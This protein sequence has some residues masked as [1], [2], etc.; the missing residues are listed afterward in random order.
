MTVV[1]GCVCPGAVTTTV[2]ACVTTDGC[3]VFVGDGVAA[4]AD[5]DDSVSGDADCVSELDPEPD[6]LPGLELV[7]VSCTEK[8]LD[9]P[10]GENVSD[11]CSALMDSKTYTSFDRSHYI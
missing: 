7:P 11:G 9:P 6:A 4:A 5:D 10:P 3:D 2:D 1:V 8:V